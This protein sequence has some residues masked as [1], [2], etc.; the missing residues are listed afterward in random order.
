M[1]RIVHLSDLHFGRERAELLRPLI[2]TLNRLAPDLVAISGDL[3]QRA[4]TGQYRAARTFIAALSARVV[5]VPGNHDT[6]LHDP[7]ERLFD[8]FARFRRYIAENLEPSWAGD[9]MALHGVNTVNPLFWQRGY[10]RHTAL[11]RL[12]RA[13]ERHDGRL[14]IVMGHHPLEHGPKSGKQLAKGAARALAALADCGADVILSG[15]LHTWRA[16]PFQT[17]GSL[18]LVQAGTGLSTRLRD[19]PNDF[20]LLSGDRTRL[21]VERYAATDHGT[22]FAR[23]GEAVF[24][25]TDGAWRAVA[26]RSVEASKIR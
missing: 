19:E 17:H 7:F 12:C 3:T 13:I 6:P 14:Q 22:S 18:L 16:V 20:N 26:S 8:P 21:V 1:T 25:K 23:I 5:C 11:I 24:S 10:I 15:H 4:R 2:E 9:T